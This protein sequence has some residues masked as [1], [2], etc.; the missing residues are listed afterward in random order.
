M[1]IVTS[2]QMK[3]IDRYTIEELGVPSLSLMEVAGRAVAEEVLDLCRSRTGDPASRA[4]RGRLA[5][6]E[7]GIRPDGSPKRGVTSDSPILEDD[8]LPRLEGAD[9]EHWL[10]LAGKG[11]NGGD[12]LA[13]ARYLQDAGVQVTILCAE[14]ADRFSEEAAAQFQA[15]GKSGIPV[16]DA[17]EDPAA[18]DFGG[19]TGLVDALLGVGASGEPREPYAGLIRAA[20]GSGL[21]IVAAD[22]PSGLNA[23][24]GQ[25][26]EACIA[27]TRTVCIAF[28]KAGLTQHP[29]AAA[30]GEV[31]VRAVGIPKLAANRIEDPPYAHLITERSLRETL[32]ID[33]SRKR[34]EDSN[35]GTYGHVL[36]VGGSRLMT[37]AGFM[38]SRAA[39]R[40]GSGLVTWALPKALLPSV[41]GHV[42]ELMVAEASDDAGGEWNRDSAGR[43]LK[44][45]EKMDVL[46]V[47]SGL[48]RFDGDLDWLRQ[49]WTQSELPLVIDADGLNILSEAGEKL[50]DWGR[51]ENV[52]LTPH[53]GEM[54][55]LL[56]VPTREVQRDRIGAARN[57][58]MKYGV[59]LV[60]KGARTVIAAPDGRIFV[61]TTGHPGMS[62]GGTG[63][64]LTGVISG[65]IAQG[66]SPV[67]ASS[68][69]AYLH[70]RAGEQ[71][72]ERR[73]NPASILAGDLIEE[74]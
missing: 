14:S 68:F 41:V 65:L 67:Q 46:A 36:V 33:T 32:E 9:E 60:L 50:T 43:V 40:I 63:D 25:V 29:G 11:N 64:V 15:A 8:T 10:V 31:R 49:I 20:N 56:G 23:D 18:A 35:K 44:L 3:Q 1:Q 34:E 45:T 52:L 54:G 66:L 12:G 30:A 7:A 27:A 42:P 51:R 38:C 13:A 53:P 17:P 39:L 24:T 21:P 58:A 6:Q 28:L 5:G 74:L 55:R 2:Q 72:A 37:G 4:R 71:A 47:G 19:Y 57:Y 48:G 62:T 61:N 26:A 73:S 59:T 16:L 70:G 22:V 69:G